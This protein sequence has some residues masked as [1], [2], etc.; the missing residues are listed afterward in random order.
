MPPKAK[1]PRKLKPFEKLQ[2]WLESYEAECAKYEVEVLSVVKEMYNEAIVKKAKK[3]PVMIQFAD[4]EIP[5]E[6]LRPLIESYQKGEIRIKILSFLN[7]KSGDAGLHVLADGLHP[8]L[9]IVGLAYHSNGVGPSGCRAIARGFVKSEFLAILELDFNPGIGDEGCAGLTNYGHCS[10]LTRLSLNYCN[11]GDKGADYLAKWIAKPECKI[12]ELLLKGNQIGPVGATAI[13]QYLPQN[14]SITRLDLADNVF[15]YD[16]DA[17]NALHDGIAGCDTVNSVS[18]LNNFECPE[19]MAEKFLELVEKKPLGDFELT[20][21]MDCTTFQNTRAISLSNAKK[22]AKEL[23]RLAKE[24]K[25]KAKEPAAPAEGEQKEGDAA[26]EGEESKDD[27]P[28]PE[29]TE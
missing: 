27:N 2:V 17:L 20:V 7:T 18:L 3:Q 26:P 16:F 23:K 19:G 21:K 10:A 24:A 8:P 28:E 6:Q 12:K 1:K 11:I 5:A 9:E 13:G 4:E 29:K 15:G 14:K 22:I 25:S